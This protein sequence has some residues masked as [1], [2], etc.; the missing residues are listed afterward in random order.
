MISFED[1]SFTYTNESYVLEDLSV[2]IPQGQFVCVLGANG[3]GKS[4]FS[5][6]IN[7]LLLPD[8]G[9]V[10]VDGLITSDAQNTF[11]IRSKAG[12]VFQN[13][14]DQIVASLVE[15]DVAFG[16]EN[17]GIPNPELRERVE[18]ALAQVGLTGF[19]KRET[20]ALSGGQKQRV[21]IAGIL[22][23]EPQILIFDEASAMLDP[24]GRRGLMRVCKEL[25]AQGMTIIMIT[26]YMEEAAEADRVLVLREGKIMLDGT[27]E[28]VLTQDTELRKLNLDIPFATQLSRLLQD[29]GIDIPTSEGG[30]M[31]LVFEH[32][33]YTYTPLTKRQIK[34]GQEPLWALNDIS[35]EIADGEF[36]AIA[37]HTGSGKSTLVLH[38]NG[39]IN[40]THG[41]VLW[42]GQDLAD[43]KTANEARGDIGV[44]FQYPENQLFAATVYED[45][46]FGP[47][48]LG[49]DAT[50]VEQRVKD[51]IELVELDYETFKDRSPFELS[52]GQQR[53]VAFAGVLAM[54][55]TTL[56]LD[57]PVA[58]LDPAS[59]NEFLGFIDRLHKRGITLVMVS[60][61]MNDIARLADRML[62]LD[63]GE[64]AFLGT[65]EEVFSHPV[66]LREIGLGVPHAQRMANE[67]RELG[68]PL[69]EGL[70][71]PET[72]AEHLVA[73]LE[74]R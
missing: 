35:F 11:S 8:K 74:S 21:A 54:R 13:P 51:A 41:K 7:A 59:R 44:V 63:R 46:A 17:L 18:A 67:L 24:R 25:H 19:E 27:P 71:S 37:G 32:V 52:G 9:E 68:V 22:A 58:G 6:L 42:D 45:V 20:N 73:L 40:P 4:T 2:E 29:K 69:E 55:P 33:S 70:Y 26:H 50:E 1:V 47:R 64:I 56:V 62:V 28:E 10:K 72:L 36:L 48:N 39:V 15:N 57:E 31:A 65:P 60:H 53:R 30:D 38:L 43:K 14:D 3:S 16:P 5:K 66:E 49:L 61:N 12:S 34:E 23:M